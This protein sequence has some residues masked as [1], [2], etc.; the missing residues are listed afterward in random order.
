MSSGPEEVQILITPSQGLIELMIIPQQESRQNWY[1][2]ARFVESYV[3]RHHFSSTHKLSMG[4]RSGQLQN[5]DFLVF[6]PL[7]N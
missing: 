6:K 7:C 3:S 1:N 4:L 5:F 2:L